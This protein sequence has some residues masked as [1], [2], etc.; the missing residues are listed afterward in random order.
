MLFRS[1]TDRVYLIL[2][3]TGLRQRSSPATVRIGGIEAEVTYA[4]AQGEF[5][6][7]DQINVLIP[8]ALSGRGG[9]DVALSVDNRSAN[10]VSITIR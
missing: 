9:V 3:A 8:R 6:G 7:L 4:G 2:Y 1:E 5:P 10:T